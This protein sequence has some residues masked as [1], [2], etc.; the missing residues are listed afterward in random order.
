MLAY[1]TFMEDFMSVIIDTAVLNTEANE[2]LFK[3]FELSTIENTRNVYHNNTSVARS[4]TTIYTYDS[5]YDQHST[6][7][8]VTTVETVCGDEY[9]MGA[10][11]TPEESEALAK[12]NL[13]LEADLI[14]LGQRCINTNYKTIYFTHQLKEI[15]IKCSSYKQLLTE[16]LK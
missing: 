6:P 15:T 8:Y 11:E 10:A 9:I 12:I 13:I 5:T 3:D 2:D 1:N 16:I 7:R 14:D 4:R